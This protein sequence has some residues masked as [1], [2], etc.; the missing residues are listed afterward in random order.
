MGYVIIAALLIY[1]IIVAGLWK[2]FEKAGRPGWHAAIP[3]WNTFYA[4]RLNG[5]F[6]FLI[7][8]L[9]GLVLYGVAILG[10]CYYAMWIVVA[11]TGAAFDVDLGW[12]A[13]SEMGWFVH[14]VY[15]LI[16]IAFIGRIACRG[17]LA[18]NMVKRI[19]CPQTFWWGIMLLPVVFVPLLGFNSEYTW[20]HHVF[21]KEW[22]E[23]RKSPTCEIVEPTDNA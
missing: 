21:Q 8:H 23:G 9:F 19:N 10:M 15:G 3:L 2:I 12:Y 7:G 6:G 11:Y 16:A 4:F 1:I 14:V 22:W 13:V 18:L 20:K 5:L 17:A